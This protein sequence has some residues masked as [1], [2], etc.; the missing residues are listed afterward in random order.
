MC[1]S[2]P[3]SVGISFHLTFL[4]CSTAGFVCILCYR[5]SQ[6]LIGFRTHF[7]LFI[8]SLI[9]WFTY[10]L[11]HSFSRSL[12]CSFI[13]SLIHSLI[14]VLSHAFIYL[15]SHTLTHS[16]FIHSFIHSSF[17]HSSFIHSLIHSLIHSFTFSIKTVNDVNSAWTVT[18]AG[19]SVMSSTV[20]D[21]WTYRSSMWD[22][23]GLKS[24]VKDW[25][26]DRGDHVDAL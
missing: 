5:L 23:Y 6:L 17:I 22:H 10:L 9:E 26:N 19:R 15:F 2:P 4:F 24:I 18:Q 8:D 13:H 7:R 3:V 11:I 1:N 21:L 25:E 12:V 16:F 14:H 20:R